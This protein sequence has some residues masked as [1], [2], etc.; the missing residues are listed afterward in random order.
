[1]VPWPSEAHRLGRQLPECPATG[2]ILRALLSTTL[3][4]R[5]WLRAPGVQ[6]AHR[7]VGTGCHPR[8]SRRETLAGSP[9]GQEP[10]PWAISG[11]L[12]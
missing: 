7:A 10:V 3:P 2:G 8:Y 1:M 12:L 6:V 11:W 9:Q 5:W 4:T